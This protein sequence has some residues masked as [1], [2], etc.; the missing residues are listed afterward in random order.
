MWMFSSGYPIAHMIGFRSETGNKQ[1][2]LLQEI[3]GALEKSFP[4]TAI[5]GDGP[6]VKI[7]F[8]SYNVEL[9][10]AFE[11]TWRPILGLHDG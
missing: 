6:V 7:P 9:V 8:T 11:L 1:S 2:Q 4:N 10:P 3:K 5:K